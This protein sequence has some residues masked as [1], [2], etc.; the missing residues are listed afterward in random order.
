[1]GKQKN[2]KKAAKKSAAGVPGKKT[3]S[4]AKNGNGKKPIKKAAAPRP[5][6]DRAHKQVAHEILSKA[7]GPMNAREVSDIMVSQG[8]ISGK[9]PQ[10]TV[11]RDLCMNPDLFAK[12]SRGRYV[13]IENAKGAKEAQVILGHKP[14]GTVKEY[15]KAYKDNGGKAPA[16]TKP[17]GKTQPAA[18]AKKAAK[19]KAVKAALKKDKKP[20]KG[21]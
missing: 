9:T 17:T 6:Y 19:K 4:K 18:K 5:S 7:A 21:K 1:M 15:T 16:P 20:G 10:A 13:A 3:A 2:T 8:E 12:V 11:G 14:V